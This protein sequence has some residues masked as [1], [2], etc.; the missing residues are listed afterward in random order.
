MGAWVGGGWGLPLMA[1]ATD[2]SQFG[3]FDAGSIG[4]G[5]AGRGASQAEGAA[6]QAELFDG[7]MV[8][9]GGSE[10]GGAE[11]RGMSPLVFSISTRPPRAMMGLPSRKP[12]MLTLVEGMAA[13]IAT[14]RRKSV[15]FIRE[16]PF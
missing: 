1:A 12:S 10:A 3:L 6:S 13:V 4:A 11:T 15:G 9:G 7:A 2:A 14:L 16:G 8:A 5:A